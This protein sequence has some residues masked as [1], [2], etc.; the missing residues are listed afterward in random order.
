MNRTNRLLLLLLGL[1]GLLILFL[2]EPFSTGFYRNPGRDEAAAALFPNFDAEAAG[3]I[4]LHMG[5]DSLVLEREARGKDRWFVVREGKRYRADRFRVDAL[6]SS[7][8]RLRRT[9]VISRNPRK[10]SVYGLE[11]DE[12]V[13]VQVLDGEGRALARLVV[14]K[15]LGEGR[16]TYVK[17]PDRVA[18]YREREDIR[19][20]CRKGGDWLEGWRDKQVFSCRAEEIRRIEVRRK[21][22]G[23]W[24]VERR[25]G[26]KGRPGAWWMVAP[27]KGK[28]EAGEAHR[29]V[30]TLVGLRAVGFVEKGRF[31]EQLG[32]KDP[33]L[34]IE[35]SL[36][37]EEEGERIVHI[38]VGAQREGYR[39]VL[40]A[41]SS[42]IPFI[43]KTAASAFDPL[44]S[45][46]SDLLEAVPEGEGGIRA[47]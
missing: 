43:C 25:L 17:L 30:D 7:L 31:T 38:Q 21:G 24:I 28:V 23:G 36:A 37:G 47:P 44:L 20:C 33:E 19:R 39:Y 41:T 34:E 42:S 18:V 35:V 16:G 46:P 10:A 15:S 8:A 26:E 14:G 27:V 4:V 11:G 22:G 5:K 12:A 2:D 6:L 29:L 40:R 13:K 32:L 3:S 45:N 1:Q 9:D